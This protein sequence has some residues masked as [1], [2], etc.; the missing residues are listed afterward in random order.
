[1]TRGVEEKNLR[2]FSHEVLSLIVAN[3]KTIKRSN[4]E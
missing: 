2:N 4:K 1:M 3:Y